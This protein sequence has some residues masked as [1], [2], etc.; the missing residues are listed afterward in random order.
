MKT[1]DLSNYKTEIPKIVVALPRGSKQEIADE[2]G[3]PYT[4][5]HNV[6]RGM[7]F[8]QNIIDAIVRR[9]NGLIKTLK[10]VTS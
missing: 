3:E 6:W 10:P 9:Y 4:T 5:V 1:I 2:T 8:K 7:T